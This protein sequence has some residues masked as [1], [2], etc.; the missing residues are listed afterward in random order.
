MAVREIF[1][2]SEQK[3]L[4]LGILDKILPDTKVW[5]YG[6]RVTG[7][8]NDKSDLDMV[9]FTKPDQK[10]QVMDLKEALAESSIPFRVDL[11]VW[12]ELPEDFQQRISEQHLAISR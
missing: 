4:I 11:F 5:V 9:V 2:T 8:C 10:L 1:I 6:S 7:K 12:D 3:V